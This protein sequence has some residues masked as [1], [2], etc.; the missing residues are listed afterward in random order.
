MVTPVEVMIPKELDLS[1]QYVILAVC[2]IAILGLIV[3][4]LYAFF[5]WN[6]VNK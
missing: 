2:V 6:E 1:N 3:G 5:V 4:M